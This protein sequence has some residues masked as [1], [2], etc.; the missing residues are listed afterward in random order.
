M[1]YIITALAFSISKPFRKAIYTNY[2]L[3]LFLL[4]CISYSV[5]STIQPDE[6]TR[7]FLDVFIL[8]FLLYKFILINLA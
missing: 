4:I 1:Q 5:Y 6:F 8:F 7:K 3:C 2:L